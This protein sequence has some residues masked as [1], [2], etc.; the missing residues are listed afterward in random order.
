MVVVMGTLR[1]FLAF[2][3]VFGHSWHGVLQHRGLEADPAWWLNAIG[4]RAVLYF[5]IISGFLMS[6]VLHEKY[7]GTAKGTGAFFRARFLRVYPLWWAVLALCWI[8]NIPPTPRLP[9]TSSIF[10]FGTD[11][12]VS[13]ADYPQR[14]WGHFPY[15]TAAGWTLGAEL[16]FYT[17]APWVLRSWRLTTALFAIS[18]AIRLTVPFFQSETDFTYLTWMYC[19]FPATLMFFLLGHFAYVT[20]RIL[21]AGTLASLIVLALAALFSELSDTEKLV[22]DSPRSYA[23]CLCFAAALPGLFASTKNNRFHN[24]LGDLTYPLYLTH[25]ITIAIIFW[26]WEFAPRGF[27]NR[28]FEVALSLPAPHGSIFLMAAIFCLTLATA[29]AAH[30]LVERPARRLFAFLLARIGPSAET[31]AVAAI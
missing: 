5:Y 22:V 11:W 4:D 19:F 10:L 7:P 27:Q 6:Y 24:F 15:G 17:I 20:S 21:P 31:A 16:T 12:I 9:E 30:Y 13:F 23:S 18:L 28:L 2:G 29:I 26:P 3:V 25:A 8:V 14:Y 1:L